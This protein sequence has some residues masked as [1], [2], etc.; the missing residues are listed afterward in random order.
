MGLVRGGTGMAGWQLLVVGDERTPE[1]GDG[2]PVVDA[3][4]DEN[5]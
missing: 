3:Q 4:G 2:V 5:E 1:V